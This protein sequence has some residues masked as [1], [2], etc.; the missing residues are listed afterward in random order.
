MLKNYRPLLDRARQ[1]C[2]M[3]MNRSLSIKG[4]VT[5]ANSLVTSIFQY[6]CSY[7]LTPPEMFKEF[8]S[9]VSA[10]IWDNKKSKIAFD[11]LSLPIT[12]GG[13]N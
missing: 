4:K 12:E 10:F 8:R 5:V 11:T 13:L 7:I 3:W 1:I 6:P 2:G 9:I